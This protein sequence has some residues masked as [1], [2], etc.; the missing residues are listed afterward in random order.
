MN[1]NSDLFFF[2]HGNKVIIDYVPSPQI[3][4]HQLGFHYSDYSYKSISC[5]RTNDTIFVWAPRS[6]LRAHNFIL[7]YSD[8]ILK[9]IHQ[10]ANDNMPLVLGPINIVSVP[11]RLDGYEIGSWNLLTNE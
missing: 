3:K 5:I 7:S 6:K 11:S 10:Y 2:S 4:L 1:L 9:L 8:T